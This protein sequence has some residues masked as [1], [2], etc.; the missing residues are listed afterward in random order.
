MIVPWATTEGVKTL[1]TGW[2]EHWRERKL[3]A[4][5]EQRTFRFCPDNATMSDLLLGAIL[6]KSRLQS[7]KRKPAQP[8]RVFMIYQDNDP[9]STDFVAK[10]QEK[11]L[12]D[13]GAMELYD[14][15]PITPVN[16]A[17]TSAGSDRWASLSD[18]V[19]KAAFEQSEAAHDEQTKR[20]PR[21]IW[22]VLAV[23]GEPAILLIEK[24]QKA[25]KYPLKER[26]D[27]ARESMYS[28]VIRL[29]STNLEA[30]S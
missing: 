8:P 4:V 26:F 6:A 2:P 25:G 14:K 1:P 21:P 11:Y 30:T 28:M 10:F 22:V 9:Y 18:D 29:D 24:L 15:S 5:Y 27:A 13:F 7:D 20:N 3:L 17:N 19:W 23:Q 12:A 16:I